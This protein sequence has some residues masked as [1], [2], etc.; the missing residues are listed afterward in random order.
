[1]GIAV[2]RRGP[3]RRA[4]PLV[5]VSLAAWAL[6]ATVAGI[7]VLPAAAEEHTTDDG[8]TDNGTDTPEDPPALS[9]DAACPPVVQRLD[10]FPDVEPGTHFA[11]INCIRYYELTRGKEA[12]DA[13]D[14]R[15]Y[16]PEDQVTRGQMASF[17]SATVEFLLDT[18]LPATE[19]FADDA[20]VHQA[21]IR[22]LATAGI[23]QGIDEDTYAPGRPV[24]RAQMASFITGAIEYIL[25]TS[26]PTGSSFPDV[27]G[28]HATA[29]DKLATAGVVS[30][31]ADGTYGP[32]QAVNRAQMASF[33][34]LAMSYVAERGVFPDVVEPIDGTP[35]TAPKQAPSE[36]GTMAVT[37]IRVGSHD[38]F[39]RVVLDIAGDGQVGW[40]V[41]YVDE[42][43]DRATDEPIAVD[44]RRFLRVTLTGLG[45]PADL[46]AG[47]VPWDG[48]PQPGKDDGL[49]A[50]V[51]GGEVRNGVQ[52]FHAGSS[53]QLPFVAARL[54]GPQRLV[55]DIFRGFRAL[56]P[57]DIE[58]PLPD[59]GVMSSFT[60]PLTPG[61]PRNV[62][63]HR[64]VEIIDGDVI[65][66][67]ATY[68]L[69]TAIGPR[70]RERGFGPNGFIADGEVVSVVGGG[71]SQV[72]TTFV[73]A[74]WFAGVDLR[75][76]RQHSIYFTRYPMCRE[77]TIVEDTLDVVFFNDSP[78]D[79]TVQTASTESSVTISFVGIPWAQVESWI[80]E[81]FNIEGADGAFSVRCGRT[82]TYPDGT[83]ASESYSWRY[84]SGYPG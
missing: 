17:V 36:A 59:P 42:P 53:G 44:G 58:Q 48:S 69:E 38:G 81:P 45:D 27:G 22:K 56:E 13:P 74:A 54:M 49:I 23:V 80:G 84:S 75:S 21:G 14:G 47:I 50:E 4:R 65:P 78:G 1:M 46:P 10:L 28:A 37:G 39:D 40:H 31:L 15:V 7:P 60:T 63:I 43:I 52:V 2:N 34:A 62:N 30:G 8:G 41:A 70:T 68:S 55:I 35:S 6:I 64:A 79:I 57:P 82:M 16:G 20:V 83:T 32:Q 24:T 77:A 9:L 76:F 33:T 11:A 3:S 67:G 29:I 73:N 25:E 19:R 66:P 5:L 61:Q 26:L 51:V 71:I 72:A 12:P 18:T